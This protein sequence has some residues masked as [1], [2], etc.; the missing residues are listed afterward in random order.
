MLNKKLQAAV[1]SGLLAFTV[2]PMNVLPEPYQSIAQAA[3]QKGAI[4]WDEITEQQSQ[5]EFVEVFGY[6]IPQ[7]DATNPSHA[8]NT[9]RRAAIVDAQR[10][11]LELIE[12]AQVTAET[13]IENL[14]MESDVI[15]TKVRGVVRGAR[16]VDTQFDAYGNCTVTM[17]MPL[18][19]TNS[20]ASAVLP[21]VIPAQPEPF[22]SVSPSYRV[23]KQYASQNYTGVIVDARGLG[24]QSAF[25]P[26]IV[27][28]NGRKIYGHKNIDSNFAIQYG[29]VGYTKTDAAFDTAVR[30]N[31]RAGENPLVVKAVALTGHNFNVV[32]SAEDGDLILSQNQE[33]GFLE[34][35]AVVFAK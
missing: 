12:G 19:G 18:Y 1:L 10:N 2:L 9:S 17:R 13:T 24:L 25:S 4:Y 22:E 23:P 35:C 27:D 31:S 30:G 3:P 32:V 5:S 29:M 26:A 6:G 14:M 28:V 21:S 8:R 7:T 20:V 11:L 33:D 15:T 34:N 16:I